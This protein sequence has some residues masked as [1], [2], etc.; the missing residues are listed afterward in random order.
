MRW[1][2]ALARRGDSAGTEGTKRP[3]KYC[4]QRWG[5]VDLVGLREPRTNRP[6]GLLPLESTGF[7]A[8]RYITRCLA[9]VIESHDQQA[10][11]IAMAWSTA[12]DAE[13]VC[14]EGSTWA[15]NLVR[16]PWTRSAG[17]GTTIGAAGGLWPRQM[18]RPR[19]DAHG[20]AIKR[21]ATRPAPQHL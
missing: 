13:A 8:C 20:G 3:H 4:S 12:Y 14:I 10:T 5:G 18:A 7:S 1:G 2:E 17:H 19:R 15:Q 11:R 9:H 21:T 16:L 6:G